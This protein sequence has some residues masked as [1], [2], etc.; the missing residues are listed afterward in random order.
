MPNKKINITTKDGK[1]YILEYT[2]ETIKQ[3][4]RLGFSLDAYAEKPMTMIELAF[5]GAFLVNHKYLRD[6]EISEIYEDLSNKKELNEAIMTLITECYETLV[7]ETEK[8][9]NASWE[10]V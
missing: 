7:D 1:K 4:E 3:L 6:K 2:R 8:E 5:R 10:I 9:G